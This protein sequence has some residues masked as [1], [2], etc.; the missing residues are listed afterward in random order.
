MTTRQELYD[1][2]RK[3]SRDEVILEEMIRLGFWPRDQDRPRDPANDI[4]R[5]G[6]LQRALRELT[7]QNRRLKDVEYLKREARRKRLAESRRK[8]KETKERRLRARQE[9]T[10][11][12]RRKQ[13]VEISYLGEGVSLGLGHREERPERLRLYNLPNFKDEAELAEAM[14]ISVS[15]LRFLAF[16][17]RT[18]RVSHYVRFSIRKKSGALRFIAAPMPRLKQ[19]QSWILENILERV[20]LHRAAHGFRR[21]RSIVTNATPHV[22]AQV[23][24]NLDLKDFFPTVTYKRIKGVYRSLGYSEHIAVILALICSEPPVDEVSLDGVDYYVRNGERLLPQGAPTSPAVTNIICRGLDA[25]IMK[26]AEAMGFTYTRYADDITLSCP[27]AGREQIGRMLHRAHH[28]VKNEGFRIHPEKTRVFHKGR[29]QEVTGL[30]VNERVAV[31]KKTL[32]RFRAT[33]YQIE[34]DGPAGKRWGHSNDIISAIEGFANFVNMVDPEKGAALKGR[35]ARI[36]ERYGRTDA[37]KRSGRRR[38]RPREANTS[39]VETATSVD[40]QSA[41]AA[42]PKPPWWKRLL[43]W[44]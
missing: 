22:G 37:T 21:G 3:S 30:V 16:T 33:L 42:T 17:R 25:R 41:E 6:E 40:A 38:W 44:R 29:R 5:R 14:G 7:E 9:R 43:F 39:P 28:I 27:K 13:A 1:R 26:A 4:R 19:A 11:A 8:R 18:S 15:E 31:P 10:E 23:V 12:W 35:V 32:K 36:I 2:I 34:K 20:P 24:I